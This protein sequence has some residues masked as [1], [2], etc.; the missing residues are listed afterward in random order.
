MN[1]TPHKN[2]DI[3]KNEINIT[4]E[5]FFETLS[6]PAADSDIEEDE[7]TYMSQSRRQNRSCPDITINYREEYIE[8]EEKNAVLQTKLDSA[9]K[10]IEELL[11]ENSALKKQIVEYKMKIDNLKQICNSTASPSTICFFRAEFSRRN[12]NVSSK[13]K[14]VLN[15]TAEN[16]Q[17]Q[18]SQN[19]SDYT[20]TETNGRIKPKE[21]NL[22]SPVSRQDK[23]TSI[24]G[25]RKLCII[26]NT[27]AKIL[28][29]AESALNCTELCHYKTP[30]AG[31][32][33][34]LQGIDKKLTNF[35][36][37]D[38]CIIF[39]G[40]T[41]FNETDS[42]HD[43]I[44]FMRM[45]LQNVLNTNVI[46]CLPT[47]R[48]SK[49]MNL[50]NRRIEMFNKLLFL[51]NAKYEYAYILD[52]NKNIEYVSEM[53]TGFKGVLKNNGYKIIFSDL[54]ELILQ[55]SEFHNLDNFEPIQNQIGSPCSGIVGQDE[56][57]FR[58]Q[59][60]VGH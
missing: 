40:D 4:T 17:K 5:N 14:H 32:K 7:E 60:S 58:D 1:S 8:M 57:L 3:S 49:Y 2:I 6:E 35:T 20:P 29:N 27:R 47:F 45:T 42:Y 19:T 22:E 46:I 31:I 9:D 26:S 34:L 18:T 52:C 43:L 16:P 28:Q 48:Y 12:L 54:N 13:K 37:Q 53:Y 21:K 24:D 10:Q 59:L 41:D 51:D 33:Q 50:Y 25:S 30:Q 23:Q 44:L 36:Y 39:I 55:I 11:L 15:K 56:E 38:Y